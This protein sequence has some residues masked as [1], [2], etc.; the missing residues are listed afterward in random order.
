MFTTAYRADISARLC[1][2]SNRCWSRKAMR[3]MWYQ[4]QGKHLTDLF[5]VNKESWFLI[6][7]KTWRWCKHAQGN[8]A[9]P[10]FFTIYHQW[11]NWH[12][13]TPEEGVNFQLHHLEHHYEKP[14][15]KSSAEEKQFIIPLPCSLHSLIQSLQQGTTERQ[16][17][18]TDLRRKTEDNFLS[19]AGAAEMFSHHQ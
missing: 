13:L 5:Q 17:S 19:P 16:R 7:L 8:S 3:S 4:R 9:F 15:A 11:L 6:V 12:I 18:A 10:H 1:F 2:K 14:D